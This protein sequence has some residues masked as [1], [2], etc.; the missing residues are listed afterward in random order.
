M[1]VITPSGLSADPQLGQL[2]GNL[3]DAAR[4][5]DAPADVTALAATSRSPRLVVSGRLASG[6]DTVAAAVMTAIG[7]PD[8]VQVSF[9]TALRDEVGELLAAVRTCADVEDAVLAVASTASIDAATARTTATL[10][11]QALQLD[12]TVTPWKRTREMRLAL[13]DWGTEVRRAADPQYWVKRGA[14]RAI[15]AIS[16]GRAVHITDARFANEVLVAKAL[17]F[18]AVRL[19]VDLDV[20]A[21]R[22]WE[23]D[24]LNIDPASENHPSEVE[25]ETFDRF[26][27]W[28]SNDGPLSQTVAEI[29]TAMR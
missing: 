4:W 5:C 18:H 21:H 26:D 23:R 16:T 15:E 7:H 25:L 11:W 13:Q 2:P 8:S 12:P 17:G 3:I 19:E 1:N 27:Q 14:R 24:G 28:V 20:R 29:L 6:K 9:A 10:L 22:L